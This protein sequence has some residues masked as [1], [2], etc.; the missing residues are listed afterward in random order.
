MVPGSLH[1]RFSTWSLGV[2]KES[3]SA[4][5]DSVTALMGSDVLAVELA[6]VFWVIM[7]GFE[8]WP[9]TQMETTHAVVATQQ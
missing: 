7:T 4:L 6:V 9:K 8:L 1:Q 3:M 5:P 2:F